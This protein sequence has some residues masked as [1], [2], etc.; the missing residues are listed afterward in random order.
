MLG[1]PLSAHYIRTESRKK[2]FKAAY[3]LEQWFVTQQTFRAPQ[4]EPSGC[5]QKLESLQTLKP[6]GSSDRYQHSPAA[7]ADKSHSHAFTNNPLSAAMSQLY[8]NPFSVRNVWKR[9]ERVKRRLNLFSFC[10]GMFTK[11]ETLGRKKWSSTGDIRETN[12]V[13]VTHVKAGRTS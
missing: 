6:S 10:W 9:Q 2:C 11:V 5:V 12:S 4:I 8:R 7:G 13:L 1:V 3:E